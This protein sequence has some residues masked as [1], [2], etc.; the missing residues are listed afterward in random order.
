[1]LLDVLAVA[2]SHCLLRSRKARY[3]TTVGA[4]RN[5]IRFLGV[6]AA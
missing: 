6:K 4:Q 1:M 5:T 3:Q 2:C